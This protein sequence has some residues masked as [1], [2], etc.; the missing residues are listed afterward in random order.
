MLDNMISNGK[1]IVQSYKQATPS[2]REDLV[3]GLTAFPIYSYRLYDKEGRTLH[4]PAGVEGKTAYEIESGALLQ[5]IKGAVYR[6]EERHGFGHMMVGLPFIVEGQPYALFVEADFGEFKQF[7][8]QLFRNQL[9]IVM[10]FGGLFILISAR[11]IV[12][13][14]QK[15]TRAT[16][17]MAKGEF[18]LRLS[19]RRKDEIGQLTESFNHMAHELGML[20][21]SRRQFVSDVSHELQSP[22]TSIQGFTQALK[23]KKLDEES[24]IRLLDIIEQESK[25]LSRLTEDLLQLSSLDYEQ[26]VNHPVTYRLD[27]QIRNIIIALEPQWAAKQLELQL[28]LPELVITADEGKLIHLWMNLLTNSIK[29]TGY[30]GSIHISG[31]QNDEWLE[32]EITDNGQGMPE[33]ELENIFQPFYKVDKQRDRTVGGNGIG[34]SIV[35]R[36]IAL[37]NGK[38]RVVSKLGEGTTMRVSLPASP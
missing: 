35:K 5:V 28:D 13:P 34:L 26:T 32:I 30:H 20:E 18:D 16:R 11:Y 37:H 38:I 31:R 33:D 2:N 1:T 12:R 25:R 21:R 4:S 23:H 29:F 9:F 36:I 15:L 22:L 7:L 24:R 6:N 27:E 10:L 8:S 17:K 3:Q 14:I 19:T